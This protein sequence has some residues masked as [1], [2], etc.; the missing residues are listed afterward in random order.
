MSAELLN[1]HV[2]AVAALRRLRKNVDPAHGMTI[3]ARLGPH[4]MDLSEVA[5]YPGGRYEDIMLEVGVGGEAI[6]DALLAVELD[7]LKCCLS[8]TKNERERVEK[9]ISAAEASLGITGD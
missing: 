3:T 5:S 4:R 1:R 6:I 9:A 7:N 2:N 8:C